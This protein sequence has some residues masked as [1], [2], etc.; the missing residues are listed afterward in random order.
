MSQ[1]PS[2]FNPTLKYGVC[3]DFLSNVSCEGT[4]NK[5]S[6]CVAAGEIR[7]KQP[8]NKFREFLR[9]LKTSKIDNEQF[10]QF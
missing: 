2:G 10:S 9:V 7:A 1:N 3:C 4:E 8:R 6:L 5:N